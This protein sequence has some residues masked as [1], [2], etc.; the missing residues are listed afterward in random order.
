MYLEKLGYAYLLVSLI[1]FFFACSNELFSDPT[2]EVLA[3]IFS[4]ML[5]PLYWALVYFDIEHPAITLI[6]GW[7]IIGGGLMAIVIT[8]DKIRHFIKKE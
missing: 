3:S 5:W 2:T 1:T 6:S 4:A 7:I 8:F